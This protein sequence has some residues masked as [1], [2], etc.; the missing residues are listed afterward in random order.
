VLEPKGTPVLFVADQEDDVLLFRH[1]VNGAAQP[2]QFLPFRWTSDAL[3]YLQGNGKYAARNLH[4]LPE[5]ILIGPLPH[6]TPTGLELLD[7]IKSH[8][9]LHVIP[10]VVLTDLAMPEGATQIYE[11]G[12]NAVS[13]L[14]ATIDDLDKLVS[15]LLQF[16]LS[17]ALRPKLHQPGPE[18]KPASI[19]VVL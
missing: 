17:H 4:P 9:D 11:R 13:E 14:P 10:V 15:T 7:F 8:P 18:K 3:D 2:V 1:A 6:S 16:W 19:A 12:A 5:L